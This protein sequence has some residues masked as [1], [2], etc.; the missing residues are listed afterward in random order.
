[1]RPAG[2]GWRDPINAVCPL[3]VIKGNP[4]SGVRR[5]WVSS[6]ENPQAG[7]AQPS[8]SPG[9]V[10]GPQ[11]QGVGEA[12]AVGLL[13]AEPGPAPDAL[14][15]VALGSSKSPPSCLSSFPWRRS[16][17]APM[18]SAVPLSIW[19]PLHLPTGSGL[20]HPLSHDVLR[21]QLSDVMSR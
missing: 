21:T 10:V 17:P 12:S 20:A 16:P 18:V 2:Q 13:T 5:E 1:M 14:G 3:G 7:R 11:G 9:R 6:P 15:Y 19:S 8:V 4:E